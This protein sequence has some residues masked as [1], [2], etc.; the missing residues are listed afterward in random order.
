MTGTKTTGEA[1]AID[2]GRLTTVGL[3]FESSAGLRR[4]L[5]RGLEAEPTLSAQS[6]DVL[7]R[8][9]RTPGGSLRMS[10]LAAES[11]LTPSGLTRAVDRL[12]DQGLVTRRSCPEDRRGAFAELTPAG[13][14]LMD[15]AI[16]D[17]LAQVAQVLD[18]LYTPEEER[19]L[20]LLLRRL[21]DY[22]L[23]ANGSCPPAV[24]DGITCPQTD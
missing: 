20:E 18:D 2:D 24:D 15:R 14:D 22:V 3:L 4:F 21:R 17:H 19:L 8:L 7:I 13:R 11:S 5:E 1:T 23:E 10:E 6:F 12:Q 9:A 16:P